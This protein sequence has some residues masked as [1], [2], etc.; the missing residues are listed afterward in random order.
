MPGANPEPFYTVW[1]LVNEGEAASGFLFFISRI[2]TLNAILT[3]NILTHGGYEV[4]SVMAIL[5]ATEIRLCA[6]AK[7]DSRLPT[8]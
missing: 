7:I 3:L 5:I 4:N 6:I 2:N 8:V 1:G